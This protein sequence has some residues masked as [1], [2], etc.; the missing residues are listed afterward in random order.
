MS[1][2]R[3]DFRHLLVWMYLVPVASTWAVVSFLPAIGLLETGASLVTLL[4]QVFFLG[5]GLIGVAAVS[6]VRSLMLAP[7][8]RA[9]LSNPV[10]G[11][12]GMIAIYTTL[13]LAAYAAFQ[14]VDPS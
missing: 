2:A 11:K 1:I 12:P 9:R 3:S 14:F 7:E 8:Q 6:A 10:R 5:T 4:C 13:W